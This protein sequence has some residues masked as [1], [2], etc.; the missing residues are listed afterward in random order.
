MFEL[1]NRDVDGNTFWLGFFLR[2]VLKSGEQAMTGVRCR[3]I[4]VHLT[5]QKIQALPL[6]NYP[7]QMS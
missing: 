2:G 4:L 7:C 5:F 3:L 1:S 6:H